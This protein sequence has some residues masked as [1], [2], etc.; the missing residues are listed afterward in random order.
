MMPPI[1]AAS[2]P[3]PSAMP[4]ILTNSGIVTE[5]RDAPVASEFEFSSAVAVARVF[6]GVGCLI[7]VVLP[8]F[9]LIVTSV[10]SGSNDRAKSLVA[11][12]ATF[13]RCR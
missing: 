9:A 4:M 11:R 3:I 8:S 1:T 12:C 7:V 10:G 6:S 13:S 2:R 5:L